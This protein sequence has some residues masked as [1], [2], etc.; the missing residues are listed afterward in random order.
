MSGNLRQIETDVLICGSGAAGLMCLAN[1]DPAL[2]VVLVSKKETSEGSTN[3][4]QGGVAC[5]IDSE[6][7]FASHIEDTHYAGDGLCDAD[8][9]DILVKSG[10]EAIEQLMKSMS[11]DKNAK[12]DL[13]LGHEG[14]HSQ[15]RILHAGGDATGQCIQK[16]LMGSLQR[17]KLETLEFHRMIRLVVEDG[18]CCGA[19]LVNDRDGELCQVQCRAVVLASGGY[20][21]IYQETTNPSTSTGDG[22]SV[23]FDAGALIQDPEFVQ[24]HPTALFLAG[25]PRFLISEAVRGEGAILRN[26]EGEAFMKQVHSMAE[27]APRDV[28]SRAIAREMIQH[29]EGCVFL[30][31]S[32][33]NSDKIYKRFPTIA[34]CCLRFGLDLAKQWIPVRPAAHYTMG[35]VWTD[36]QGKTTID[37]LYACGEVA[38][39]G[40][41]GA[42][43]LASNSLLEAL[44]YGRRVAESISGLEAGKVALTEKKLELKASPILDY[45]DV[46]R[47]IRSMMWRRVGVFRKE[48]NLLRIK[49]RLLE[50]SHLPMPDWGLCK[51]SDHMRVLI[52]NALLVTEGAI[53]RE[54][55]R[56]AHHRDDF[57]RRD[58]QKFKIHT[59]LSREN[60]II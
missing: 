39:V 26:A 38:S 36:L 59:Q 16:G 17:Q 33:L 55:S 42:N 5:V 31:L 29:D 32:H 22:M 41:H 19:I 51:E 2:R 28:V 56:G 40:V 3:Y 1:L 9:V 52:T 47:T 4:A 12:G 15:R 58:D 60:F 13:L 54:E 46:I 53:L 8:A 43:R 35:G 49:K 34:A 7:S 20:S 10:P 21:Q 45:G 57:P 11:F 37:R 14:A 25:A 44:V 23:A 50:W 27:L 24:F 6:D 48:K 30:D 18:V